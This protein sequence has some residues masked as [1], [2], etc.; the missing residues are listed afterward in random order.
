MAACSITGW[1]TYFV[2]APAVSLLRLPQCQPLG[3][4]LSLVLL[5]DPLNSPF[6]CLCQAEEEGAPLAG[7]IL[8]EAGS[9]AHGAPLQDLTA[10]LPSPLY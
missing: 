2:E 5:F 4:W 8:V 10:L 6:C 3:A 1:Q 7:T 9:R